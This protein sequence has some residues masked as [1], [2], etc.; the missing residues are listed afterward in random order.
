MGHAAVKITEVHTQESYLIRQVD[1][2]IYTGD[3]VTITVPW[4]NLNVLSLISG[5]KLFHMRQFKISKTLY[6]LMMLRLMS[7]EI[8]LSSEIAYAKTLASTYQTTSDNIYSLHNVNFST[9]RATAQLA[10]YMFSNQID[11]FS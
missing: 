9:F 6:R 11:K 5:D 3:N 8:N 7:G 10:C 4:F 2:T 1:N